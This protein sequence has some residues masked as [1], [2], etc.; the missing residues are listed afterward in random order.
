MNINV[1]RR[2]SPGIVRQKWSGRLRPSGRGWILA[3]VRCLHVEDY[4]LGRRSGCSTKVAHDDFGFMVGP[5][6]QDHAHEVDVGI[7]D[8]L[9]FEEVVDW[10]FNEQIIS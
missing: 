7:L 1:H 2:C 6:V 4:K 3:C 9:S 8:R 10:K 5:I